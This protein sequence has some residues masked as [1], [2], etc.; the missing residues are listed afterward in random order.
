M[1][2]SS[3]ETSSPAERVLIRPNTSLFADCVSGISTGMAANPVLLKPFPRFGPGCRAMIAPSVVSGN[4]YRRAPRKRQSVELVPSS[5]HKSSWALTTVLTG[6]DIPSPGF[7]QLQT[8]PRCEGSQQ[9]SLTAHPGRSMSWGES[10]EYTLERQPRDVDQPR[11][12]FDV[13]LHQI[14][15]MGAGR[16]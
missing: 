3:T 9:A 10:P 12:A 5:C 8:G 7:A 11:G 16:R 4:R 2:T 13:L 15:Q 1:V 6:R 14:D